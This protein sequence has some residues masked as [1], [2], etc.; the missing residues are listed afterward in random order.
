MYSEFSKE[1]EMPYTTYE[2]LNQKLIELFQHQ[3]Y[4]EALELVTTEGNRFSDDRIWI[5]YWKMV[6]AARVGKRAFV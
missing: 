4:A 5:D 2:Q 3:Q 1:I 6:S